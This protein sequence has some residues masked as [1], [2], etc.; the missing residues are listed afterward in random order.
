[1]RLI[2]DILGSGFMEVDMFS[3][4]SPYTRGSASFYTRKGLS[5]V[6]AG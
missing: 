1:M 5:L 3:L 4:A 2:G 6:V